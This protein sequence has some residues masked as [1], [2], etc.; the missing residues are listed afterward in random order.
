MAN[1]QLNWTLPTT[2]EDGTALDQSDIQHV[3]IEARVVGGEFGEINQVPPSNTSLLI[4]QVA[5]G[6][7]EFQGIVVDSG[8]RESQPMVAS[9]AVPISNPDALQTFEATLQ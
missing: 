9:L 1:V 8:G 5:G 4:E 7:W 6:D 2:R 3:R